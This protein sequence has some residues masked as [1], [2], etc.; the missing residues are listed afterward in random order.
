MIACSYHYG[1]KEAA[2]ETNCIGTAGGFDPEKLHNEAVTTDGL[3]DLFK[4]ASNLVADGEDSRTKRTRELRIRRRVLDLIQSSKEL[5]SQA[6]YAQELN[7]L[8]RRS[9]ALLQL[10]AEKSEEVTATKQIMV[11]QYFT[12]QRIPQLEEEVKQLKAMTWYREEAEAERKHLMTSLQ[13]MKK[14]RD[15][16]DELLTVNENENT[17][18]MQ[19]LVKARSEH[20]ELKNRRWWHSIRDFFCGNG[21]A[22]G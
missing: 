12:L 7:Y 6:K 5:Q 13:R 8:Q 2:V 21:A 19:L 4:W 11:A 14:E 16:L 3:E 20:A 1:R 22:A 17:R 9:I 15:F 18:L 10:L